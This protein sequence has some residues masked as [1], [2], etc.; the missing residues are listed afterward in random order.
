MRER[1]VERDRYLGVEVGITGEARM[2]VAGGQL[3]ILREGATREG[4][5]EG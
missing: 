4:W 3:S 5:G 2:S 1:T